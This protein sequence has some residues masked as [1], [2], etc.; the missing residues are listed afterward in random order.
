[1][2]VY[3]YICINETNRIEFTKIYILLIEN[4][5]T[6]DLQNMTMKIIQHN[7]PYN[8]DI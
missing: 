7:I 1:M 4:K 6:N 8:S 5:I 3:I 2:F